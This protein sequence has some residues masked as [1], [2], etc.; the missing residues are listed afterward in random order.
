MVVSMKSVLWSNL[1]GK[2]RKKSVSSTLKQISLFG[3]LN[4]KQ[5]KEIIN[6][7][8]IRNYKDK[9]IIFRKDEPS[10]G[11]F[12]VLSGQVDVFIK[13]KRKKEI[14]GSYDNGDYFGEISLI[15][16]NIR[17]ASAEAKGETKLFY[18]FKDD[19]KELLY[20]D[21]QICISFYENL[22]KGLIEKLDYLDA[23]LMEDKWSL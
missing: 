14:L 21:K 22:T 16:G 9:E 10:Y 4:K 17:K 12:I 3:D 18:I 19:L 6:I 23:I 2:K 13:N 7:G 11:M 15:E 1:L 5:I 8:H 20:K